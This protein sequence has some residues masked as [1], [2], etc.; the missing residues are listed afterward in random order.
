MSLSWWK[1][2]MR[3]DSA[4]EWTGERSLRSLA[5]TLGAALAAVGL[6][7]LLSQ[8]HAL[9]GLELK[10]IDARFGL[11]GSQKPP[12]NL[13]IV[14]VD[15]DTFSRLRLQWPFPRSLDASVIERLKRDGARA[16]VYDVQF[17]EPTTPVNGTPA[18]SR[19]AIGEDNALINE[20]HSAGN[21]VLATSEVGPDGDNMILGGGGV[22]GRIGARAGAAVFPPDAE[23]VDR[24]MLYSYRGLRTLG[25]VGAELTLGRAIPAD[26]LHGAS[27]WIDYAGPAGT[28]PELSFAS[29]LRGEVP[30]YEISG[31]TVV[32][33]A[34]ASNL[35]DVHATP[36]GDAGLMS[37]AEITANAIATADRG[38]PLQ[39]SPWFV[40]ALLIV[41]FG[42]LAPVAGLRLAPGWVIAF[43]VGVGATYALAVQLAFAANVILPFTG[44]MA[45]LTLGCAGAVIGDSLGERRRLQALKSAL[46]SLGGGRAQFFISYRRSQ[47]EWPAKVLNRALVERFGSASVFM[48]KTAIDAGDIWPEEIEQAISRCSV[49][50]VLIGPQWLDARKPDGSRRLDDDGDWVCREIKAGLDRTDVIVVPVLHDGASM[51]TADVLPESLV[52]L[53]GCH[54]VSFTGED[55]DGEIGRLVDSV[56]SGRIRGFIRQQSSPMQ[57]RT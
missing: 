39:P 35:Q 40:L 51:P 25:I 31:K 37:G 41:C 24:R 38:F 8:T 29:V 3:R 4:R 46:S 6:A 49:M 45:A 56:Q 50:L 12:A 14:G 2:A 10:S 26:A 33:G 57:S 32:V 27:A 30:P 52:P 1:A 11:R 55:L 16:I 34:T 19:A 9:D 17:T 5:P 13:V 42:T 21:V 48:D 15:D 23:G 20:V 28:Y 22:L 18:A 47:S 7:L 43:A 53:A 36:F 44:P 54:A